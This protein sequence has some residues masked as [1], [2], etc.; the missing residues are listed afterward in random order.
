MLDASTDVSLML[1]V[2][3]SGGC[4]AYRMEVVGADI[5]FI[6]LEEKFVDIRVSPKGD[7][8][9]SV[10]EMIEDDD[11]AIQ[12]IADV[13]CIVLLHCLVLY[14][15]ILEIAYGIEGG[16][17]IESAEVTPLPFYMER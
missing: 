5:S 1:L 17:A 4:R 12:N 15:Y 13:R 10:V 11:V 6:N 14:R 9:E 3:E 8:G 2:G 16:V 7:D